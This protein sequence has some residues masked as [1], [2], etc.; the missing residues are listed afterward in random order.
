MQCGADLYIFVARSSRIKYIF[1]FPKRKTRR[2][3]VK[4]NF[5]AQIQMLNQDLLL[6]WC[7]M[8]HRKWR[9]WA[10]F[11]P[12]AWRHY[13]S[14]GFQRK[15]GC[16]ALWSTR[17]SSTHVQV[18]HSSLPPLLLFYSSSSQ[19]CCPDVFQLVS[20]SDWNRCRGWLSV[21]HLRWKPNY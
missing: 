13:F 10:F 8:F 5:C 17:E 11:Y 19:S 12:R 15:E 2:I 18:W 3:C 4:L 16:D 9:I 1:G 7:V 14:F 21:Q 20:E 6:F